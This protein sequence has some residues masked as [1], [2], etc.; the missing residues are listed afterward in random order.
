M[1]D[2]VRMGESVA[3]TVTRASRLNLGSAL[4]WTFIA[5]VFVIVLYLIFRKFNK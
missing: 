3:V 5:L 4:L 1:S 2:V